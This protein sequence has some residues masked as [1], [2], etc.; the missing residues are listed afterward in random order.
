MI[1]NGLIILKRKTLVSIG[2][3]LLSTVL[4]FSFV[5]CKG[6]AATNS[7]ASMAALGRTTNP[8]APALAQNS[9]A[10]VVARVAPAVV[11]VRSERRVRAGSQFPFIDDPF[12]RDFFGDRFRN[13]QG[14]PQ[15]RLQRGLAPA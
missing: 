4:I 10:D 3:L 6:H 12:F 14:E 5:A 7:N 9:Y 1:S 15:E 8:N 11:T 2:R 13:R